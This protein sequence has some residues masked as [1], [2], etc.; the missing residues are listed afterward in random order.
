MYSIPSFFS[1]AKCTALNTDENTHGAILNVVTFTPTSWPRSPNT[2]MTAA[3]LY[4]LQISKW[5]ALHRQVFGKSI[6]T[7]EIRLN[8]FRTRGGRMSS[9]TER[10]AKDLNNQAPYEH[11]IKLYFSKTH[12]SAPSSNSNDRQV[13]VVFFLFESRN[14]FNFICG[15]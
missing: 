13:V 6:C 15:Q 12:R 14:K 1:T 11:V 2:E 10:R 4:G 3:L 7:N 8:Q 9:H 5:A